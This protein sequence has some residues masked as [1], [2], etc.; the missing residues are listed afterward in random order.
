[1]NLTITLVLSAFLLAVWSDLRFERL[2]PSKLGWRIAHVAAACILLQ[3]VSVAVAPLFAD[4][5]GMGTKLVGMLALLLPV[6]VYT[7]VSALW[8][9]RTLAEAGLARR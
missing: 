5:A 9:V 1:M 6:F 7:F 4:T 3:V 2:R 8:L